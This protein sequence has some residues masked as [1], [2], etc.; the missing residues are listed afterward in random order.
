MVNNKVYVS[1]NKSTQIP[2]DPP[3][4]MLATVENTKTFI[5]WTDPNDKYATSEGKIATNSDI[6]ISKWAYTKIVKKKNSTPSN[7]NDGETVVENRVRNQYQYEP[8]E[9]TVEDTSSKFIYGGFAYNEDGVVSE[10][11][12]GKPVSIYGVEWDGT[13]TTKWVRTDAAQDFPEP[14]PAISNGS[15]SSPFDNCMPWSGMKKVERIGGTMVSIPKFWYKLTQNGNGMKLQIADGPTQGFSVSPAHMDRGDGVGERSEVYIGRYHCNNTDYKSTSG[16]LPKTAIA[17]STAYDKIH[18]I[19]ETIWANDFAMRFTIWL[20]YLVEFAD[21]NS[22][23]VI[24]TG[25]SESSSVY[26]TG[27]TDSMSYHTGTTASTRDGNGSCQYRFIEDLWGNCYDWLYGWYGS[28][29]G[30]KVILNPVDSDKTTG[31]VSIGSP[32]TSTTNYPSTFS[33]V[34]K[35]NM[36]TVFIPDSTVPGG[37]TKYSCDTWNYDKQESPLYYVGGSYS[38]KVSMG[39]FHIVATNITSG[40]KVIGCRIM[41]LP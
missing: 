17:R 35:E 20:L 26:E 30:L 36:F 37:S 3:N 31:G 38:V 41:E 33:V 40:T 4:N 32:V 10:I 19:G 6:L 22:Q 14:V 23:A 27:N 8:F 21:W 28:S 15:G 1:G 25:G 13:E 24:G 9:D 29:L 12:V 7:P 16:I 34:N 2:L 39:L 18:E 11:G 5:T